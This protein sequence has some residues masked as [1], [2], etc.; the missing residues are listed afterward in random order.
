MK[1]RLKPVNKNQKRWLTTVYNECPPGFG[2]E[3]N[4]F[5]YLCVRCPEKYSSPSGIHRCKRCKTRKDCLRME[6]GFYSQN[7]NSSNLKLNSFLTF[8]YI[9]ELSI[10]VIVFIFTIMLVRFT[11]IAVKKKNKKI[12]EFYFAGLF[13]QIPEIPV[14]FDSANHFGLVI[15][16]NEK[17]HFALTDGFEASVYVG[18]KWVDLFSLP[19]SFDIELLTG[20][21]LIHRYGKT[22]D[23][24]YLF[25][26]N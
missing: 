24:A 14:W 22:T 6:K 26:I 23:K 25:R 11:K 4:I 8:S 15:F 13:H 9:L 20:P 3:N 21:E 10:L 7:I 1:I 16:I 5:S 18:G 2:L 17:E 12:F 19:K